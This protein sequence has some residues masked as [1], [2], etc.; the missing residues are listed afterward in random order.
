VW[1]GVSI[2]SNDY[3]WRA[4]VLRQFPAR[5]RWISAE[6]LLGPLPEMDLAGIHWIV[7][8][9]ESGPGYRDMDHAWARQIR[10]MARAQGVAFYFKQSAGPHAGKGDL[11]DGQRWREFPDTSAEGSW[12]TDALK[13]VVLEAAPVDARPPEEQ[14]E[15]VLRREAERL[16]EELDRQREEVDL[17]RAEV[18]RQ[19]MEAAREREDQEA[20][21]EAIRIN[22]MDVSLE[23]KLWRSR[24][25][26]ALRRAEE[27]ERA[28][29]EMLLLFRQGGPGQQFGA[30][31]FTLQQDLKVLG[32]N[33]P[34]TAEDV[35]AAY[36][37]LVKQY[38]PDRFGDEDQF[39]K[40]QEAYER[41]K[42]CVLARGSPHEN[43]EMQTITDRK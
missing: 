18:E 26:E 28:F 33:W 8:G 3:C 42:Q 6:P 25:D 15:E 37:R 17:L 7:V 32:L 35:K 24:A 9:G 40:V 22:F 36:R 1:L 16:R 11:L 20:S 5:V 21:L 31:L 27:A 19:R 10:D 23:L 43:R 30:F 4:D 13:E 29:L 38:H 34:C 12:P 2:E 14:Q 39:K 41:L